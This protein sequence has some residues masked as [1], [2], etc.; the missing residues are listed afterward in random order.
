MKSLRFFLAGI[1]FLLLVSTSSY[2]LSAPAIRASGKD[3]LPTVVIDDAL[4]AE[5]RKLLSS[6]SFQPAKPAPKYNRAGNSTEALQYKKKSAVI[7]YNPISLTLKGTMAL[8]Q[9]VLSPQLS[10]SCPYEITCSNF[11]KHAIHQFGV[12]KGLMMSADRVLRCNRIGLLDVHPTMINPQT[13][14]ISDPLEF[15]QIR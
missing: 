11:S 10:R 2:S 1:V 8:Y 9:N 3:S 12:V 6:Q 13:G 5:E 4:S 15:Y 14:T 7:R